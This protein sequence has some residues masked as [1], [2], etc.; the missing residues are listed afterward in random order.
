LETAGADLDLTGFT[1]LEID[2]LLHGADEPIDGLT[3]PDAIPEPPDEPKTQ[4]GDVIVLGARRGSVS[5]AQRD[6]E[7]WSGRG[8]LSTGSAGGEAAEV[9]DVEAATR[10]IP[11][12]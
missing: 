12:R 11:R 3:D 2:D 4:P 6:R 9:L 8:R 1:A 7:G 5:R 10:R